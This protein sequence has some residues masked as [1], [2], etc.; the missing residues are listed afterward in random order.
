VGHIPSFLKIEDDNVKRILTPTY[1]AYEGKYRSQATF[2]TPLG[3]AEYLAMTMPFIMHY[4]L[5]AKRLTVK[6]AAA[7][8]VPFLLYVILISGSRLGVVGFGVSILIYGLVWGILRWRRSPDV[9]GPA[10]VLAYPI[11]FAVAIAAS[12]FVGKIRT[13][14]WGGGA[15]LPSTLARITQW[16]MGI[17]KILSNPIGHGIGTGGQ[18]LGYVDPSGN[19][20]IDSYYL[21]ILLEFG[22]FGFIIYYG[23]IVAS[24]Y[25][26]LRSV[27]TTKNLDSELALLAPIGISLSAFLVTKAVFSNTDNHS[28]A[29]M[30]M[31]M[32]GALVYRARQGE[33]R[34][35]VAAPSKAPNLSRVAT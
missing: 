33:T 10:I 28:L 3:M 4:M 14:V 34:Q 20:T 6:I 30:M 16:K 7:I 13:H 15:Q 31:G 24:I 21:L 11:V 1:R 35:R 18:V 26:S 22:F 8:S 23:L 5:T 19:G 29:F 2:T 27:L 25:Y 9:I 17:P 12:L 32:V